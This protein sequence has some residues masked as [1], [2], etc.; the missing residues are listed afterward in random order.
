MFPSAWITGLR[1]EYAKCLLYKCPELTIADV[2]AKSG[3][4]SPSHFIRLFREREDCSP[5]KWRKTRS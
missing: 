5:A 2:S 4:Q 1:I 3:F